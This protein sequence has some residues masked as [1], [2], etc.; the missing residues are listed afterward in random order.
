MS[1]EYYFCKLSLSLALEQFLPF[2]K[3]ADPKI[4]WEFDVLPI[5]AVYQVLKR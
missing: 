5:K 3:I 4:W 2:S 1:K